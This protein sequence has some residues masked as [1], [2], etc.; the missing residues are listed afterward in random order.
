[1]KYSSTSEGYW[2]V[3]VL[4]EQLTDVKTKGNVKQTSPWTEQKNDRVSTNDEVLGSACRLRMCDWCSHEL[5]DLRHE[6]KLLREI[7]DINMKGNQRSDRSSRRMDILD[8]RSI[9][10][11]AMPFH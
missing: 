9:C 7:S 10:T 2:N 6:V 8:R 1:M 3:I 11:L 5:G 4:Y